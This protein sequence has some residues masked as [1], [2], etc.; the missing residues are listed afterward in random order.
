MNSFLF[1]GR[2]FLIG[3]LPALLISCS[4]LPVIKHTGSQATVIQKCRLPFPDTPYRYVHAIEVSVSGVRGGTVMGVTV[5]NPASRAVHSAIITLEGFV[6]FEAVHE[7]AATVV[8]RA[9]PPFDREDFSDRMIKDIRLVFLP[10]QGRLKDAGLLED[11]AA[12][13]R[14]EAEEDAILDVI[15]RRDHTWEI[16]TYSSPYE[17]LCIISALSVKNGIPGML[18]LATFQGM[19]Y[20]LK[21][22]LIDA[23]PA[24]PE[25]T[26]GSTLK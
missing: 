22:T 16:G 14:Y 4:V 20:S 17:P 13:C 25:A 9:L 8:Q 6:L 23:E 18:E 15:V 11:G 2:A 26:K 12:L 5:V 19:T 7:N 24:F 3:I 1:T 10:P 21:M